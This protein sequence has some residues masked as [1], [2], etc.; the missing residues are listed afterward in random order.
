MK[1]QIVQFE[2][3]PRI[4]VI[5]QKQKLKLNRILT[6]LRSALGK[7]KNHFPPYLILKT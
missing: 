5:S 2:C 3:M 6:I 1:I 4:S 7:M